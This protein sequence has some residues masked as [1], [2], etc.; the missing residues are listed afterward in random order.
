[1]FC[2]VGHLC[3]RSYAKVLFMIFFRTQKRN[4]IVKIR[5]RH[6]FLKILLRVEGPKQIARKSRI[7]HFITKFRV[8]LVYFKFFLAQNFFLESNCY[9]SKTLKELC[10]LKNV[11]NYLIFL[12]ICN[13]RL[14]KMQNS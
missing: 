14:S 7:S 8:F 5:N 13:F 6:L 12:K 9:L 3:L 11:Q 2:I 10:Y 1:M 4:F